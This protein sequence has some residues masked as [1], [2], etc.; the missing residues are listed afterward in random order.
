MNVGV[1]IDTGHSMVGGENL[2]EAAA[3]LMRHKKLFHLH[4]NDN[5]RTW[6]DDMIVGS[7]NLLDYLELFCWLHTLG[8]SGWYSMDQ[9]PYREDGSGA[10]GESVRWVD[11]MCRKME[12]FGWE[13][14]GALVRTG[15]PVETSRTIR[16]FLGI[17]SAPGTRHS[18]SATRFA[19]S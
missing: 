13:R 11:G 18:G 9:Y 12:D 15:D 3:L 2:A 4:C 5:Y 8:Y 1:C 19:E 16:E 14:F 7:V 6:D 17:A 10:V